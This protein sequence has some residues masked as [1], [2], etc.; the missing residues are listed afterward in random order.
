MTESIF[1]EIKDTPENE[2]DSKI[3]ESA[4]A[5]VQSF[6]MSQW[7]KRSFKLAN[8]KKKKKKKYVWK[9]PKEEKLTAIQKLAEDRF[10]KLYKKLLK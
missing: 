6:D 1:D 8:T 2:I 5:S 7:E 3:T 4:E 10:K 9:A